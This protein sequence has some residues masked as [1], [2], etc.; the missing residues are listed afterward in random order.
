[1]TYADFNVLMRGYAEGLRMVQENLIVQAY[2]TA[3]FTNMEK[4]KDLS[5]Y[6]A[7][8]RE[9]THNTDPVD[10]AKALEISETIERLK[11]GDKDD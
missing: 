1:M 11:E 2:Y 5:H 3:M 10:V 8:L 9:K 7:P 4:P 6:L